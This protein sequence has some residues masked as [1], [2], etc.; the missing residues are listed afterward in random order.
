MLYAAIVLVA[1]GLVMVTSASQIIAH[2]RF[3]SAY[4][5]MQQH[6][7]RIALGGCMLFLFMKIDFKRYQKLST[8]MLVASFILLIALFI[9][10]IRVRG[11]VRWLRIYKFNMQPVEI[12]KLTLVI[13]FAAKLTDARHRIS[14]FKRGFLPLL[15]ICIAMAIIVALQPNFSNAAF[16]IGLSFI[17]FF[18]GGCRLH[19]IALSG[20][21]L[22]AVAA[23][24]LW[25]QGHIL[26]RFNVL[27]GW[28][29]NSLGASYHV[30]QSLIAHGVGYIGGRGIGDGLQK[31]HF[32]PD[33]H[34]D[35]IY[36]IIGEEMGVIG[37]MFVLALFVLI[38]VRAVS[39]AHRAPNDFGYLL[40]LGLGCS[41][42]L[43]AVINMAMTLGI[44]PVVGLPLPFISFGGTSLVTSLA[45]IGILLNISSQGKE[46]GRR[47]ARPAERKTKKKR[48]Y[49]VKSRYV[50]RGK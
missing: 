36:S 12:A 37:T 13:F 10:G 42:F 44:F 43:S 3:C 11:A 49:A 40:S 41:L 16:I 34:T 23:P 6:I 33:A 8:W 29:R 14:E 20:L 19:H 45:T 24:F 50:R 39:N 1:L 47:I 30:D 2:E 25:K 21:T 28:T 22:A 18:V 48:V 31:F 9:W 27:F 46:G 17:L 7:I 15:A 4:F 38:L 32:L 26:E 5:F 35:F